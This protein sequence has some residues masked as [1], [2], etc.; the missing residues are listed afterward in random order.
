MLSRVQCTA[1]VLAT[2]DGTDPCVTVNEK[3]VIT[4]SANQCEDTLLITAVER[5]GINQTLALH[6]LVSL[7]LLLT[8][9]K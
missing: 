9:S 8:R 1:E 2:L 6:V 3:G 5:F 4:S 7:M